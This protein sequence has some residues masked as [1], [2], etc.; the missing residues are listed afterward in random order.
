MLSSTTAHDGRPTCEW[1]SS[2]VG[3]V[4]SAGTTGKAKASCAHCITGD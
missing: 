3:D 1:A 4:S 2:T